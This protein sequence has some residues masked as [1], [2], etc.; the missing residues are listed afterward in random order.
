[1]NVLTD[2]PTKDAPTSV[3]TIGSFDGCHRGH[4]HLFKHCMTY[5]QHKKIAITFNNPTTANGEL[6]FS[7]EQKHQSLAKSGFDTCIV[8]K[9]DSEFAGISHTSFLHDYLLTRLNAQVIVTG[10]NFYFGYNR[11]GNADYL[12]KEQGSFKFTAVE[13]LYDNDVRISS[14]AIRQL[15]RAGDVVNANNMLGYT[16]TLS[17]TIVQG[18]QRG[19]EMAIPTMNLSVDR[20]RVVPKTGVYIGTANL[21]TDNHTCVINIGT[22]PTFTAA[23]NTVIEAHVIDLQLPNLYGKE[24]KL[25]FHQRLRAEIKFPTVQILKQQ[26]Q[27]DIQAARQYER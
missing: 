18:M 4:Q 11:L 19:Q 14:S 13:L 1:M 3:V 21:N 25:E 16:Y 23:T 17:G 5:S 15:L 10:K 27:Q 2:F 6:L 7:P 12:H 24:L 26:I 22:R 8:K 9:F 20:S